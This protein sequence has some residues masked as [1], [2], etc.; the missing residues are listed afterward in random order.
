MGSIQFTSAP[1][2]LLGDSKHSSL[3]SSDVQDTASFYKA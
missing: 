2:R 3:N 1:V